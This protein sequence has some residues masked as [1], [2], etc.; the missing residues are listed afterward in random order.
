M[1]RYKTTRQP[2]SSITTAAAFTKGPSMY[3]YFLL[4][5]LLSFLLGQ[6]RFNLYERKISWLLAP[7][8]ILGTA[9][10][11][12]LVENSMLDTIYTIAE[13][14]VSGT[15]LTPEGN[16]KG[17]SWI[18][19]LAHFYQD[20]GNFVLLF[21][22][23]TIA[24]ELCACIAAAINSSTSNDSTATGVM[25]YWWATV[26]AIIGAPLIAYSLAMMDASAERGFIGLRSD[27]SSSSQNWD[28]VSYTLTPLF[29]MY[30]APAY[31]LKLSGEPE[32]PSRKRF[33]WSPHYPSGQSMHN[34]AR[35]TPPW[36][37]LCALVTL[38][39]TVRARKYSIAERKNIFQILTGQNGI[40][41]ALTGKA[42]REMPWR[43]KYFFASTLIVLIFTGFTL[44][45]Q[46][47]LYIT[48]GFFY[49]G[50]LIIPAIIFFYVAARVFRM[51][52]KK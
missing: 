16:F 33:N 26:I 27:E 49:G 21:A 20:Q 17:D 14:Q 24:I 47:L 36:L 18:T 45:L 50:W 51:F 30:G 6:L 25:S 8:Y 31:W 23:V 37:I 10:V 19:W 52:M 41:Q 46:V 1:P 35:D 29:A 4:A 40:K 34:F 12:V 39:T 9:T 38:V 3:L 15:G 7:I 2:Q 5:L 11:A 44:L 48:I 43:G 42:L 13:A 28:N 22:A 32:Y